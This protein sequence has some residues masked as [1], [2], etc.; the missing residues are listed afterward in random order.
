MLM[1][2][3]YQFKLE[4]PCNSSNNHLTGVTG[5]LPLQPIT[6]A[7]TQAMG[8]GLLLPT[9]HRKLAWYEMP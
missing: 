5:H 2:L 8:R 7:S 1:Q 4:Y 3:I 9:P 6:G